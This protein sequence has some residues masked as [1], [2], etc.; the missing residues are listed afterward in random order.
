MGG[1]PL[2]SLPIKIVNIDSTGTWQITVTTESSAL[3]PSLFV[4]LDIVTAKEP[5][6]DDTADN[7][8]LPIFWSENLFTLLP[9][10]SRTVTAKG[11]GLR[12]VNVTAMPL[13]VR[14]QGWNVIEKTAPLRDIS[15]PQDESASKIVS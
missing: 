14:V 8:V 4:A 9:G 1:A 7:R 13:Y 3:H 12:R 2:I 5:D 15:G 6:S 10:E 11:S